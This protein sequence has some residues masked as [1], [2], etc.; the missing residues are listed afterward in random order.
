M[1]AQQRR[2]VRQRKTSPTVMGRTPLSFF[3]RAVKG[4]PASQGDKEGWAR[5]ESR[6]FVHLVNSDRQRCAAGTVVPQIASWRCCT[7]SREPPGLEPRGKL[8]MVKST[9]SQLTVIGVGMSSL[10]SGRG[11]WG[12]RSCSSVKAQAS[13][14][15]AVPW[16]PRDRRA[17]L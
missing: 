13:L 3:L 7:W 2:L 4:A 10:K 14:G 5:P 8:W 9:C 12:C 11:R 6:R 15:D 17:L 16:D 1:A